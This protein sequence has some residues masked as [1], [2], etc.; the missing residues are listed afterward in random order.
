MELGHDR[1]GAGPPL[2]LLH[3]LGADRRVWDPVLEPLS[4]HREVIAVDLPGFGRSAPLGGS[5]TPRALAE[6]LTEFLEK[7]GVPRPHVA[8]N[9]LGG[10]VALEMG[11]A[12][13]ARSV[14]GVAP[15]GLWPQPLVPKPLIARRLARVALP[16]LGALSRTPAGRRFLLRGV[17]AKPANVPAAAAARLVR[18]YATAPGF[19]EVNRCM[20]ASRFGG[21][22]QIRVPVTL[23]WPEHDGLVRPPSRVPPQVH[24]LTL[25]GCG[26]LPMWDDPPALT[27]LLL[28][29]SEEREARGSQLRSSLT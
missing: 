15:A 14:T 19:E 8:G 16:L 21:M 1:L 24:S 11:L 22:E 5:P 10:W 29:S 25:N 28:E 13:G 17:V 6:A 3:P 12:G 26:H 18:S 2:V 20:R 9:S 7:I 4:K 23:I 27:R